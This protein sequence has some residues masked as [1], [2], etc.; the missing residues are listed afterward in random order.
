LAVSLLQEFEHVFPKEMPNE[1]PPIRG[2]EHQIDFVPGAAI[3]NQP[4]YRN[5]PE[6]TKELQR[7]VEDLMSKGYVRE[8]MSQCAVPVLLVRKKDGTW[9]M[10]VDCRAINNITVK[11]RHP[12][13]RLNDMLDELHGS[14]IFSKIDLKSGYHQIRMKEGDEWKTAFKTKYGLYEWLVLPFGLTNAPSMFMRLMNHALRAF[15]GR[16]VVVYFDNILVYSKSLDEYV[17]YLHCVLAVLR[18]EKLN[19]NLKKCSFYLD[20]VVFLGYVVSAKGIAVNEEKVKAVK[21]WPTTKSI[22]EEKRSIAYFSEKLNGV[23]LNY[24]TYDKELYALVGALETW[25]HYLWPKE[26]VIHTDHESLKHLKGQVN[27]R[28]SLDGQK[29]AEM[30]KKLHESVQQHIEKRTEQYANKA[31]KGRR[32]IIFEPSDWVWV[33]MRKERFPARRQSKLH[34]R[35]D[36]PFQILEK[37]NDNAYK[38]DLPGEYKVLLLSIFLIFLHLMQA[39]IRGRI[40]LRRGGMM[41]TKVGLVLKILCKFQMGQLQDQEP[42]RSRKQCKDWCNPLGMKLARAQQSKWI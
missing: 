28:S 21:E 12:I 17:D 25:Q 38:V 4:A 9:R 19:A 15:L 22:T 40:L 18:K 34:P 2:I 3:P 5:N 1:L 8:S 27:G 37:I 42:R 10:C 11:Y 29:K 24:Q 26:F 6:E 13:P 7:Q 20:K 32:Q 31:D 41:G 16:F 35:G 39:K 30:V 36:G 14:C 23:A 33:H